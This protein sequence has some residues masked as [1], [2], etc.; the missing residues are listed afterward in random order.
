MA[1][2]KLTTISCYDQAC[3]ELKNFSSLRA[4][5]SG[6]QTHPIHRLKRIW[7]HVPQSHINLLKELGQ[8]NT[9]DSIQKVGVKI[10]DN[11]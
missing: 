9:K 11:T 5:I 10:A 3:R 2:Q 6:L 7:Q 8:I 4:I 1:Q